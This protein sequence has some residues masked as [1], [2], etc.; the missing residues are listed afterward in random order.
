MKNNSSCDIELSK[1][2]NFISGNRVHIH[3]E[4]DSSISKHVI[5]DLTNIIMNK[6]HSIIQFF[7]CSDGGVTYYLMQLLALIEI[8][9]NKNIIIE[10]YVFARA[11]SCGSILACSG[12]KDYRFISKH[13][14]HLCHLG[15]S[16]TGIVINDKELERSQD[17]V[18]SHFDFIREIYKKYATIENL[19]EIIQCD[20]YFI[21][22]EDI[23]KNGL[24]DGIID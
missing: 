3:G 17:R 12:T 14:E 22:G 11:Y 1:S 15:S 20:N 5:P 13:A 16:T 4:F 6:T 2:L 19:E 7:I 18:K 21:R 23:I 8:A 10:T 24:A 9:K